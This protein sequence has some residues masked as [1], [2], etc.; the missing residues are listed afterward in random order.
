MMGRDPG[1]SKDLTSFADLASRLTVVLR[2]EAPPIAIHFAA[3]DVGAAPFGA[4]PAPPNAAG[5]TGAV[6]AGCVFWMKATQRTFSTSAAD[7]ANCSVGSLTHGWLGIDE[8]AS[9][10]D[11]TAVLEAGWVD[12]AALSALPRVRRRPGAIV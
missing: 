3:G 9:R 6:S 10:D 12:D 4:A 11:V 7:H 2:L 1:G 5:R 8:A